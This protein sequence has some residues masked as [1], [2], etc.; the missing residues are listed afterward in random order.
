MSDELISEIRALGLIPAKTEFL[1]ALV[2]K[3]IE[4]NLEQ[5][6]LE[7]LFEV[8]RQ[9][10]SY[11]KD[12]YS[13]DK[14]FYKTV[15]YLQ[16]R[17]ESL[18]I[19]HDEAI[20]AA[21]LLLPHQAKTYTHIM[22]FTYSHDE[23]FDVAM[24]MYAHESIKYDYIREKHPDIHHEKALELAKT[25]KN[26]KAIES[27]ITLRNEFSDEFTHES[28]LDLVINDVSR[29][30][31]IDL[32]GKLFYGHANALW[33]V[34]E[35]TNNQL[36][37]FIALRENFP[38][39]GGHGKFAL[40]HDKALEVVNNFPDEQGINGHN[41]NSFLKKLIIRENKVY[42]SVSG[43]VF[44]EQL[45]HFIKLHDKLLGSPK[46]GTEPI[47]YFA[48]VLGLVGGALMVG[49]SSYKSLGV[50][51]MISGISYNAKYGMIGDSTT[52][53]SIISAHKHVLMQDHIGVMITPKVTISAHI[54]LSSIL[55]ARALYQLDS[56]NLALVTIANSLVYTAD[57]SEDF[58]EGVFDN[59][60]VKAAVQALPGIASAA[61]SI[62]IGAV[63]IPS[64][65]VSV[66]GILA[67]QLAFVALRESYPEVA[68]SL[69]LVNSIIKCQLAPTKVI[70]VLYLPAVINAADDI[71]R[72]AIELAKNAIWGDGEEASN[73]Y[74][75]IE[76]ET[77]GAVQPEP[78][79]A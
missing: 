59:I 17:K 52:R 74:I 22:R 35:L 69:L 16:L 14:A 9:I 78:I 12:S 75:N 38:I 48:S 11:C 76:V 37:N 28:A 6:S 42:D 61:V 44:I 57:I 5:K 60:F 2:E 73:N 10:K 66:G 31:Y 77:V 32:R 15:I 70:A 47:V 68:A 29:S 49:L 27:Y 63:A 33:L 20:E 72:P 58:Y 54:A 56:K 71:L 34:K 53:G 45:P 30:K 4:V 3:G 25:L 55:S 21:T 39:G 1:L 18:E 40:T 79:A 41:I 67:T 7:K 8:F 51:T 46:P 43:V 19:S 36:A 26:S 24:K 13:Q 50:L 23:A 64:A 62:S 65:A